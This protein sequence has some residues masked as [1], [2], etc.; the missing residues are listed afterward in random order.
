MSR[1]AR[2]VLALLA[3]LLLAAALRFHHL[4]TQSFWSDEGNSVAMV[5][6][7]VTGIFSRSANDISPPLYYLALDLWGSLV[8]RS[9]F[10]I[11]AL[12]TLF[13][14]LAVALTAVLGRRI[15]G[16]PVALVAAFA[17]AT[18]PYAI[19]YAQEARMYGPIAA[20]ALG[21]WYALARLQRQP[22]H[23]GWLLAYLLT[24]LAMLHT[25]YFTA[26]VLVGGNLVWLWHGW[27]RGEFRPAW[28]RWI[29]AQGLVA[30]LFLPWL[31]VALPSIL[32]WPAVSAPLSLDFLLR[33]LARIF[34]IGL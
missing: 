32:G 13:S 22:T 6:R 21:A 29:G 27:R 9:E 24:A 5:G 8:G 28:P 2:P 34:S 18:S 19:H 26:A 17:S 10:A 33:E 11:R 1:D 15:G 3:I 14:L 7:S 23:R 4:D 31:V 25:Q 20:L 30:V 12:S 16:W